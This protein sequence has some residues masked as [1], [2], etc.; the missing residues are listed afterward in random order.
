MSQSK[1]L[2]FRLNDHGQ[3]PDL[4]GQVFLERGWVAFD[5]DK[6]DEDDW[7]IWWRSSRFRNRDYENLMPWQRLNHF[8]KSAGITKKDSLVRN[9]KRMKGVHG[10]GVYSFSP[11]SFNLPNDYTRFVNEFSKLKQHE[12]EVLL[13]ICKP[14]DLSRGRGIFIFKDLSEL[15]YDCNAVL[16]RYI[17]NPLLIGGYKCD[18]RIYAAVPSFHPLAIYIFQEGIVRFGT[19]KFDLNSIKNVFAHLTN[20]SINKHSPGYTKDKE[21]VG[22]GCKWTLTQLRYYFHQ[23]N[24]NDQ[25]MWQKI[26]HIIILTLLVQA[27]QVTK[28]QN[29]FELY[30]FDIL[31]DRNLKP[32]L[33]EVNF[34]PALSVD[35]QADILVK[36]PLL[37][38]LMD[39]MNFKDSDGARSYKSRRQSLLPQQD[40]GEDRF[41]LTRCGRGNTILSHAISVNDV[42]AG[43]FR[44]PSL[45]RDGNIPY[46]H[47]EQEN[48]DERLD[49]LC[50]G[51]PLH[52]PSVDNRPSSGSSGHFSASSCDLHGHKQPTESSESW[53]GL[54][55][56]P[57]PM[58]CLPERSMTQSSIVRRPNKSPKSEHSFKKDSATSDSAIS[59][60][61]GSSCDSRRISAMGPSPLLSPTRQNNTSSNFGNLTDRHMYSNSCEKN[62]AIQIRS[63]FPEQSSKVKGQIPRGLSA[64]SNSSQTQRS[65]TS[66]DHRSHTSQKNIARTKGRLSMFHTKSEM[67]LTGKQSQFLI[68]NSAGQQLERK[69]SQAN[70][71][72]PPQSSR[73]S[74]VPGNSKF[75]GPHAQSHSRNKTHEPPKQV[76][77]FFQVFPF[78]DVT[79]KAANTTLDA[80]VVIKELQKNLKMTIKEFSSDKKTSGHQPLGSGSEG[81]DRLWAPVRPPAE[82]N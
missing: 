11:V 25:V 37:H 14:A 5:E 60:Q 68:S 13:W 40:F 42:N 41:G 24:I 64:L 30:G 17:T 57:V 4:L 36:K 63:L 9:M 79:W 73:K 21:R 45:I 6:Q 10:A 44:Q 16:Q 33:L 76:G 35:C 78:N 38:D 28:V 55:L 59:S 81:S 71:P 26:V 51:L 2:I 19:E 7:N 12:S 54:Q 65:V 61:S 20:T 22:H 15:Q 8:P 69:S 34:S 48:K 80:H 23:N 29:C 50:F 43:V 1:A 52:H 46:L 67:D 77:D 47:Q 27:P 49:K 70:I 32:W 75:R 53:N 18:L 62:G 82:E 74:A 56:P 39:M 66:F 72:R 31:I 3:G 58:E